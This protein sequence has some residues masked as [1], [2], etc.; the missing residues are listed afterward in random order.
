MRVYENGAL[1]G[2]PAIDIRSRVC[3]DG[4]RG[5]MAVAVDPQFETNRFIYLYYTFMKYGGASTTTRPRPSTGCRASCCATT[6]RWIPLRETVLID[7]IP[8]PQ[9]NHNGADLQFGKD[10][11]LYVATGDGGCD[12]AGDSGCCGLQRC[13]PR[14]ARAV[15][16][17]LRITRDGA[18]PADN[19]CQGSGSD[20]LQR[21]RAAPTPATGARRPSPGACATRSGSRSTRTRRRPASSS[22]TSGRSPGRRSTS[23][24][25]GADYGWNVR[26]G[27]LRDRV[28]DRMRPAA[29]RA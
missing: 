17:I 18:I 11:Y 12:Y 9:G 29:R 10:G 14:P 22:T 27:P 26:E 28:D 15:G 20:A 5:L 21:D 19:P 6:T 13:R 2:S 23:G 25:A 16:K 3:S 1:N 24:T 8:A 4:E 7:N